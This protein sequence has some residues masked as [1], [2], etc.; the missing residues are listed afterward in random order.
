MKKI[1]MSQLL[2]GTTLDLLLP[3]R[4]DELNRFMNTLFQKAKIEK[5]VDLNGE[6]L[7]MSN[8]VISR[9]L[10]SERCSENEDEAGEM[11]KLVTEITEIA[12]KFNLSDH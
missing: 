6:L 8:N 1:I 2:N 12:G 7:K 9:M 11:R 5:A 4:Q 3:V 10:M